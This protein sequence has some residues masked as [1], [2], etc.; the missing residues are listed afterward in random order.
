MEK[1]L[2]STSLVINVDEYISGFTHFLGEKLSLHLLWQS[3]YIP[4]SFLKRTQKAYMSQTL[5]TYYAQAAFKPEDFI[6][7]ENRI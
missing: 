5:K 6:C 2:C 1:A 7:F 4:A 3:H